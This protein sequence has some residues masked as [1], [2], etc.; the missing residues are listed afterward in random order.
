MRLQRTGKRFQAGCG[1]FP[2]RAE[3]VQQAPGLGREPEGGQKPA[4]AGQRIVRSLEPGSGG[5]GG[6]DADADCVGGEQV[7][8]FRRFRRAGAYA[9]GLYDGE[10]DGMVRPVG[11]QAH[12]A[13]C[14]RRGAR[15]AENRRRPPALPEKTRRSERFAD[16]DCRFVARRHGRDCRRAV[17]A[18]H[19]RRR[20]CDQTGAQGRA[21]MDRV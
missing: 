13:R 16:P 10:R 18:E 12:R 5:P 8:R 6:F 17:R 20:Y 19:Q 9:A 4:V 7:S 1:D 2:V 14:R 21:R 3:I 11:V 15:A